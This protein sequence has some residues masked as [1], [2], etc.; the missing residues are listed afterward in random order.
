MRIGFI[1]A[2]RVGYTMGKYLKTKG[3][4]IA[5]YYSRT[6]EHAADAAEFTDT[7]YFS[8]AVDL[9][10]ECD[11]VFITV[12]DNAIKPLFDEIKHLREIDGRIICHTSG[13]LSSEIFEDSPYQVYGYSIHPM[14][15]VS[16]KYT[17]YLN[18]SNAFITIEGHSLHLDEMVEYFRTAG[19]STGSISTSSKSKYH[20]ACAIASNLVCGIY[21]F[22]QRILTEC[23]MDE[24]L[25]DKA[26]KGLFRDNA[27]GI[28]EKGVTAQLTGPLERNDTGTVEKH[29]AVLEGEDR[30]LYKRCSKEVLNIAKR[31][32]EDIDYSD[33]EKILR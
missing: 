24:E 11:A 30:E 12:S 20:A 17:S 2:G 5:G 14:Y 22:S 28:T 21:G 13:A 23:G 9:I 10:N 19:L 8:N 31:K 27:I 18:F 1:G 15:A 32:H 16:D 3:L 6:M 7:R 4:D 25:S 33:M 29:M 26:L